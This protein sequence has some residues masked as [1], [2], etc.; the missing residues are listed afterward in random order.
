MFL[1]VLEYYSGILFLTTNRVGAIDEAFKSRIHLSLYYPRLSKSQMLGIFKVNL[2]RLREI[3]KERAERLESAA[4]S[5][6]VLPLD[7]RDDEILKFAEMHWET[8]ERG[9]R[10]NG[11]QIRNAFQVASSLARYDTPMASV[12]DAGDNKS[13][14]SPPV[15][16]HRQFELVADSIERFDKYYERAR[17]ESD[18]VAAQLD[19]LRDD[20]V[21]DEDLAPSRSRY[22]WPGPAEKG[23]S[24]RKKANSRKTSA[25]DGTR[26]SKTGAAGKGRGSEDQ[27]KEAGSSRAK[28]KGKKSVKP[29]SSRK[30]TSSSHLKASGA[31]QKKDRKG[32]PK[33]GSRHGHKQRDESE[34]DEDDDYDVDHSESDEDE[35]TGSE[36]EEVDI[37][38][39]SSDSDE[40]EDEDD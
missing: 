35:G 16:D 23:S 18:E 20:A 11:R 17:G 7:I 37:S 38:E 36:S 40:D 31:P 25:R 19:G 26:K 29:S 32:S 15:M 2:R 6:D 27:E 30:E 12:K 28:P 1:R 10:W 22:H 4:S 8:T 3:E 9:S 14:D 24:S 39:N 34:D 33:R 13:K 21:R 5:Q